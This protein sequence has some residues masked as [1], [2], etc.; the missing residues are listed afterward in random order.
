MSL[1]GGYPSLLLLLEHLLFTLVRDKILIYVEFKSNSLY[2]LFSSAPGCL[3]AYFWITCKCDGF[4]LHLLPA[5]KLCVHKICQFSPDFEL[6]N[7]VNECFMSK[8]RR[9]ILSQ[10]IFFTLLL[11]FLFN[12]QFIFLNHL[13]SRKSIMD[14]L[15]T[16]SLLYKNERVDCSLPNSEKLSDKKPQNFQICDL[17]IKGI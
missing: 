5:S 15:V 13:K 14:V 8:I 4:T 7:A 9:S 6:L 1:C 17:K 12:F 16:A 11:S 3:W 10:G 2:F